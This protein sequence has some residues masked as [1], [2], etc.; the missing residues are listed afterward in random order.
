MA[1]EFL[2]W[3]QSHYIFLVNLLSHRLQLPPQ[4]FCSWP[5]VFYS[6]WLPTSQT[7]PKPS[8]GSSLDV[9]PPNIQTHLSLTLLSIC[10]ELT[11]PPGLRPHSC[12]R[13]LQFFII[14]PLSATSISPLDPYQQHLNLPQ[15][16]I[17]T[18][19]LN[20][21]SSKERLLKTTHPGIPWWPRVRILGFLHHGWVQSLARE[22]RSL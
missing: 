14:L 13:I 12:L 10:L 20:I 19:S 8:E 5:P 6:T 16:S 4:T 21:N 11:H 2:H 18:Q 3:K 1:C 22:L 9:V 7:E 15:P 17:N